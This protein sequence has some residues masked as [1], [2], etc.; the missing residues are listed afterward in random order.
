M[1]ELPLH[2]TTS[3]T[4]IDTSVSQ[5]PSGKSESL[6]PRAGPDCAGVALSAGSVPALLSRFV[7]SSSVVRGVQ[8]PIP[9]VPDNSPLQ[10]LHP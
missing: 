2:T 8:C 3:K 10:E 4:N 6:Q 9:P 1:M 7:R 5:P